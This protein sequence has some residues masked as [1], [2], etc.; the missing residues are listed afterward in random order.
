MQLYHGTHLTIRNEKYF[1]NIPENIIA[2]SDF[3]K[4]GSLNVYLYVPK[5]ENGFYLTDEI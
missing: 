5:K 4:Y 3:K 1:V 2:T